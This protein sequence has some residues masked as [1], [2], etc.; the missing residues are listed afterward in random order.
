MANINLSQN[1]YVDYIASMYFKACNVQDVT[2]TPK[3]VVVN[4]EKTILI[5]V[6]GVQT[7]TGVVVNTDLFPRNH[8]TE[9]DIAALPKQ[10]SDIKFRVGYW[11]EINAEGEKVLRAGAPKWVSYFDGT[12]EVFL[13]GEKREF[14]E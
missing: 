14:G 1:S 10:L 6:E 11:P 7:S 9:E 5:H 4:G 2:F 3:E 13:S 12:K 8:A